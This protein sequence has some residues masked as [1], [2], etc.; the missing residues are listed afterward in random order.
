[1]R[2]VAP[3]LLLFLAAACAMDAEDGSSGV[4]GQVFAG[5]QCPVEQEGSPC[6]DLPFVGVVV[7]S[8]DGREVARTETDAVGRF[9]LALAP[10]TYALVAEGEAGR[11]PVGEPQDVIVPEGTFVAITL[12]VDTG[13]R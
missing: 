4:R 8:M 12:T 10:G 11:F 9:E 5:P 7:A 1:M 3:I 13:I 2:R 6:P